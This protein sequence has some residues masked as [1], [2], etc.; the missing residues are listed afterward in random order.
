MIDSKPAKILYFTTQ[1][2][3]ATGG[4]SQVISVLAAGMNSLGFPIR[5]LAP[6]KP[7]SQNI[8][9]LSDKNKNS[10]PFPYPV[11]PLRF[12]YNLY[13]LI[14]NYHN[15]YER[16][17]ELNLEILY[18]THPFDL[19]HAHISYP[20]GYCA[21]HWGRRKGIPVIITCHGHD[22]D[23]TS[24]KPY[25][26]DL[27]EKVRERMIEG[28]HL[29]DAVTVPSRGMAQKLNTWGV[30]A[31][32]IPNGVY[33]E[34]IPRS[35]T[36]EQKRPFILTIGRFN[37][38]KGFDLLIESFAVVAR[39]HPDIRLVIFGEGCGISSILSHSLSNDLKGR[40]SF[41]TTGSD[42]KKKW[43]LL[44][45]CELYVCSSRMEGFGM[46]V[47]EAMA[48]SKPVVAFNVGGL[49]DLIENGKNGILVP[50]YDTTSMAESINSILSNPVLAKEMAEESGKQAAR[51]N[52]TVILRKYLS[53]YQSLTG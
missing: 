41:V 38:V 44:N 28:F 26:S 12:L 48:C 39:R 30:T 11:I 19:I 36:R 2:F 42:E 7:V 23:N 46:A 24:N 45:Q 5:L 35:C 17:M 49:P 43:D 20:A 27:W 22:I 47:L 4:V 3:P 13:P 52:W 1:L 14:T 8:S 53:L 29:A 34:Q 21:A 31:T 37:E 33:T 18:Q 10:S 16:I 25:N 9:D 32:C 15:R 50:P 51:F 40:I 6:I